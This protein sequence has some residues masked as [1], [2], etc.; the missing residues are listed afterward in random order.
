MK[1]RERGGESQRP[2]ANV[3]LLLTKFIQPESWQALFAPFAPEGGGHKS[4]NL[5]SSSM[6]SRRKI[7]KERTERTRARAR[8]KS[9]H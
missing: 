4:E 8:K 5:N 3:N 7:K 9:L 2:G 1:G 6:K